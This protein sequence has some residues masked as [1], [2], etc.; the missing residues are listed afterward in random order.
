MANEVVMVSQP[1]RALQGLPA[2]AKG[3]VAIAITGGAIFVGYQLYRLIRKI[4]SGEGKGKDD[5]PQQTAEQAANDYESA[6]QQ[7]QKLS[8]TPSAYNAAA[9]AII[10]FLDGC[11]TAT[12][13]ELSA[14]GEVIKIVKK[15]ID[16]LY[17]QKIFGQKDIDNCGWGTGDTR[18]SLSALLKDQLDSFVLITPIPETR[19]GGWKVPSGY[20]ADTILILE[21]Y[22]KEKGIAF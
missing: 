6:V 18:Y 22:M 8:F 1:T 13:G 11:E 9:E 20:Y 12:G 4:G 7:G 3:V 2:W 5:T 19:L 17:L 21:K 15:P 14:I 10:K 16:W